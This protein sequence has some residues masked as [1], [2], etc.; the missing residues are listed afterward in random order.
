MFNIH[1]LKAVTPPTAAV[2]S[3]TWLA[4]AGRPMYG[5]A[6]AL[7]GMAVYVFVQ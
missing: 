7:V 5:G 2:L 4:N 6:L 1:L 3:G